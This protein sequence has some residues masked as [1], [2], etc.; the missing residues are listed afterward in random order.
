MTGQTVE[1]GVQLTLPTGGITVERFATCA[2]ATNSAVAFNRRTRPRAGIFGRR[3]KSDRAK[4][5]FRVVRY[6]DWTV[7]S[8]GDEWG[9]RETW[10]DGYVEIRACLDRDHADFSAGLTKNGS[11]RIVVS[12]TKQTGHWQ[13]VGVVT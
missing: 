5:V 12:R 9:V 6:G 4:V 10:T 1:W 13:P 2:I 11:T 3:A 8:T 7:G